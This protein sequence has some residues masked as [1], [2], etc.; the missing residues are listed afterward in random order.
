M[1]SRALAKR[2]I[3]NGDVD[4]LVAIIE[5]RSDAWDWLNTYKCKLVEAE[6]VIEDLKEDL[7]A[8]TW[9]RRDDRNQRE[10]R[11]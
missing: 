11:D 10:Y 9:K 3:A 5:E 1:S 6:K 8:E 7:A 4:G 2:I